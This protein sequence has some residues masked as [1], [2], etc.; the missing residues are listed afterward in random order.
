[1]KT[2]PLQVTERKNITL[3]AS[4][5]SYSV[6]VMNG[7]LYAWGRNDVGQLGDGSTVT[8]STPVITSASLLSGATVISVATGYQFMIVLAT[9]NK[10]YGKQKMML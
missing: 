5:Q 8:Q 2:T 6:M 3:I 10:L 9:N 7:I 4:G 1:V